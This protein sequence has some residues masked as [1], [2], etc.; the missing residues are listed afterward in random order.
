MVEATQKFDNALIKASLERLA[1]NPNE[2]SCEEFG[3]VL[4]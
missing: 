2:I 3:I 4:I 1:A